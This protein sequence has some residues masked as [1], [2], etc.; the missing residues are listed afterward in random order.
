MNKSPNSPLPAAQ[1]RMQLAQKLRDEAKRRQVSV[2]YVRKQYV[3]ALFYRRIFGTAGD[4]WIL[5]GRV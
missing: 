1:L 3:F 5:L 4:E 2:D